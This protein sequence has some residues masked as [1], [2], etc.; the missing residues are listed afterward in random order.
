MRLQ[1]VGV[2]GLPACERFYFFVKHFRVIKK[3]FYLSGV[4]RE[5]F[6][7]NTTA[8]KYTHCQQC[9]ILNT[10]QSLAELES[11]EIVLI[12]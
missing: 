10:I 4:R 7:S 6:W 12:L 3:V 1:S 9:N 8:N 5:P 11:K 2:V